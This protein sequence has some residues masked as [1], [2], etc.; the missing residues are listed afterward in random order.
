MLKSE[1]EDVILT[2]H[3]MVYMYGRSL[4]D[5]WAYQLEF[6]VLGTCRKTLPSYKDIDN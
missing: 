1:L 5:V 2:T 4:E 6:V 3:S